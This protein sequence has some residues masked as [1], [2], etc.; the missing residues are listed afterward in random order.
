MK[1]VTRRKFVI[2]GSAAAVA[3]GLGLNAVAYNYRNLIT[4]WWSGTF[5]KA[6]DENLEYSADEAKENGKALSVEIMGEGAVLLKNNGVLPMSA[7]N[8]ALLGYA[9]SDPV[10]IGAGSVSQGDGST[11][12]TDFYGAFSEAGFTCDET[13]KS[14]YEDYKKT[15][16]R[17][18]LTDMQNLMGSDYNIYDDPVANYR[19]KLDKAA[20]ANDVAVVVFSRTGGENGDLPIDMAGY[21]NGDAGKHYLALQSSEQELLDYAKENFKSV[22]VLLDSSNPMELGFLDDDK[23]SAAIWIG[24]PGASGLAAI[25]KIMVGDYNPS[26]HLVDIFPY[27]LK[28]SPTYTTCTAGTY[29]NYDEFDQTDEGY[30]NKVD[31]GM[32]WYPEGIFMG[33]RYFE[34]ADAE[35]VIDYDKTVQFPFGFGLSYTTFDWAVESSSFGGQGGKIE[36]KVKV[37]NSGS[38][39]GKDV[40]QLYYAA[41]YTDGGI[42]KSAKVLGAFAKT[43]LL[44][45][46]ASETVTLEMD[47]DDLA[48]FDYKTEQCYVAEAG[49]YMLYL[50]TDSHHVK[51]GCEPVSYDI[52]VD[53]VYNDNGV[54]KRSSDFV[55]ACNLFDGSSKGDGNVGD[56]GSIPWM[57][58]ADLGGTHPN[59]TMG[60]KHITEMDIALGDECVEKMLNSLGG[61]DVRFEDDDLYECQSLVA[62]D[63]GAKNGLSINDVAGYTEWNDP[64][65][66]N[67]VNQ[68][69][70]D[71]M[72]TLLCDCAYGTPAMDSIGK[73]IAT[74][75][76][77]PAGISSQNLNYYG[78]EYCGEPVTAATWNVELAAEMGSCVGDECLA[79]GVSGW[80][81]P[82]SNL[83]RTPFGGRCAEYYAED[84]L[85][86]G[87][88]CA[89]EIRGVQE[90]GVYAYLKHFVLNDQDN[91]RGGMYTWANEQAMRELYFRAFEYGLKEGQAKG[92][93]MAYPRIGL[94][95]CSVCK[96]LC[97]DLLKKEWGSNAVLITDGYGAGLRDAAS[98]TGMTMPANLIHTDKYESPDLQLR[99]GGGVLLYT[100]GYNGKYGFTE[101]TT[102][103]EKGIEM[104]HDMCKRVVYCYANSNAV[105][106][107]RDY[108]PYW[109]GVLGAIDA[110]LIG[111]IAASVIHN[112]KAVAA[113][114]AAGAEATAD[115]T[116][117][118]AEKP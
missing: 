60:G 22:I 64:I 87:K 36:V 66:D 115:A 5:T 70:V 105:T 34:T 28:S 52:S 110:L 114:K 97:T 102:E 57:T 17:D 117:E 96:A 42:E 13:M 106:V 38:V 37:T 26:G 88:I 95:E 41:P 86:T 75:I 111:G 18:N 92:V 30:D 8:V 2:G 74:D 68:M 90:K 61:S 67:L 40:V 29:N 1:A 83:H 78:H 11:P 4:R 35:G 50:Q 76:D 3:A 62:V 118:P 43:S 7:G 31:G 71:E 32:I 9:S 91:L 107:S 49:T 108:T 20:S 16:S 48:S 101:K 12:K 59:K 51:D 80:Y 45:P 53:R 21:T 25:P 89:A 98:A 81:A 85:L 15:A 93:M 23:V 94:M 46:G 6:N 58:R 69:T 73:G 79:A 104:L 33:Y 39:A 84:P 72:C 55:V 113:E 27:D 65:W 116:D 99:A 19:E 77:G 14:Y 56:G 44:D 54:G 103:S 47:V 24:A 100:G 112:N 82:G 63:P 109:V 10:Y